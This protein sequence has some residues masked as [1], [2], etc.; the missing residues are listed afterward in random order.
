MVVD[1][2]G[3]PSASA[4]TGPACSCH[5]SGAHAL[6]TCLV[7]LTAAMSNTTSIFTSMQGH[8][9][10]EVRYMP[11]FLIKG[12]DTNSRQY[13]KSIQTQPEIIHTVAPHKRARTALAQQHNLIDDEAAG[14]SSPN[15]FISSFLIIFFLSHRH[16]ARSRVCHAR[17]R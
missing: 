11:L 9:R 4:G 12:V 10:P 17:P 8:P 6:T 16:S 13:L 14:K 15:S 3:P 1:D 2:E 7:G 5:D